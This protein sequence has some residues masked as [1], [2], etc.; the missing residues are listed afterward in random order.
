[1]RVARHSAAATAW[2]SAAHASGRVD[3]RA[4]FPPDRRPAT[5]SIP[6]SHP[7]VVTSPMVGTAYRSPEPGA[8]PFVDIGSVVKAGDTLL[9]IEAMKTMNQIP[10]PRAGTVTQILVED[11]QPVEYRRAAD[12][13]RVTRASAASHV[14]KNPHRQPRRDR[15]ARAARLQ[16]ARHSDR[17]GAF[18][19]RRRRHACAAR[20]RERVHRPAAGARQLSQHPRAARRLRDHRRRRR[21]SGLR[22]PVGERALRRNP[23]RAR[24]PLHRPEAPSTSASWATRSRPSAPPSGSAF[25]SCRAPRAASTPTPRRSR[26]PARSAIRC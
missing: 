14:R 9:I 4:S 5:P 15:A 18:D 19:R 2:P 7:G 23:R 1:M 10:A 13:R 3:R 12:H 11:A 6:R 22:L 16:G 21:A 25:R 24:H 8:K 26:S 17:R 20:R